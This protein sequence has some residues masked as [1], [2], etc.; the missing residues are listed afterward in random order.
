MLSLIKKDFLLL[1]GNLKYFLI[2]AIVF[3]LFSNNEIAFDVT[4]M[5]PFIGIMMFISTFNYDDFNN[6]NAY[7]IT[8]PIKRKDIV[9]SKYITALIII[10]ASIVLGI[11]ISLITSIV[12]DKAFV[13]DTVLSN[14]SGTALGITIVFSMWLPLIYKFGVEKGRITLF[15][16]I[17]VI[18]M[19]GTMASKAISFEN[20]LESLNSL[21]N[22]WLIIIPVITIILLAVSY[23]I[24]TKIYLKKEF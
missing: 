1:K 2:V 13:L 4:F 6:W 23:L 16:I 24:S 3:T 18:V 12:L 8:L 15:V 5:L 14:L 7:A 11:V 22:I 9:K 17:F 19:I 21:E 20:L 10:A